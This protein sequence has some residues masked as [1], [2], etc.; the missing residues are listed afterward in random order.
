MTI[1]RTLIAA[2]LALAAVTAPVA[3]RDLTV[4]GWGGSSQAAQRKLYYE[5]FTQQT[6][7]KLIDDSWSGGIGML[8]TKVQG[9]NANWDVVQVEVDELLLGC[10]EG[11]YEKLDWHALG[12]KDQF[13][14]EAVHDCGVGS[15]LWGTALIYDADKLSPGP[16]SWADFWDVKKFPGKRAL[17][18]GAKYTLEFALLADGVPVGEVYKVLRTPEGIERAFRKLDE[19]KPHMVWWTAG[20]QPMQLLAS[21]EVAMT[22]AYT[23]RATHAQRVEKR[24]FKTVW[25]GAIYAVD[26]WVIL[27]GSP[28]KEAAMKLVT[29]MTRPEQ[30]GPY[31]SLAGSSATNLKAIAAVDPEVAPYLSTFPANMA[32]ARALDAEFWVDNS[33]QLTQRFN[34]WAAR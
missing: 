33:D 2:A 13:L 1:M 25:N 21:G 6:G 10:D 23:S 29:F 28:N 32:K 22:S 16:Q 12:G 4:T 27:K 31:P 8:R 26:F 14:P 24:N 20:S 19:I 17:R 3:A 15:A 9:G 18:K 34:A 11:L 30:Q 7:I 5:P